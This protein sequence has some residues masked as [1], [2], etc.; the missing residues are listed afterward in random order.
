MSGSDRQLYLTATVLDQAFLDATAQDN[1]VTSLTM[2]VDI[3]SGIGTIH[4]SDRNCYVGS[5]FYQARCKFPL[6]NRQISHWLTNTIEFSS[7][8]IELNNADGT[9]N[10][11]ELGGADYSGF[12]GKSIEVKVGLRDVASTY[13]RIF[14][15]VITPV[16]GVGRTVKSIVLTARD[17]FQLLASDFPAT[18]LTKDVFPNL[19]SDKVGR[20]VPV[21]YGTWND[22]AHLNK[23]IASIPAT[24]V[25]G[26]AALASPATNAQWIIA[27]NALKTFDA[28]N[29]F[30]FRNNQFTA[31]A[32][33]D[34]TNVGGDNR[35]FEIIQNGATVIPP[36]PG[37]TGAGDPWVYQSG[38]TVYVRVVGKDLG[39]YV[40]NPVAQAKDLLKTY[41]GLVDGDFD[42]NWATYRDKND[43]SYPQ[44]AI[45]LIKSRIWVQEPQ[46]IIQYA[47]SLL[48][49]VRLEAYISRTNQLKINSLH[50]EDWNAAPPVDIKNWDVVKDSFK[51]AIDEQNNF[52]RAR[53]LYD[54]DPSVNETLFNTGFYKN[55]AAIT[56][57][58]T[59]PITK[60]ITFP[61]LYIEADVQLQ[62]IEIL[63]L[64]S[65]LSELISVDLTPRSFLL[66]LGDWVTVSV[67]IGSTILDKVPAMLRRIGYDPTSKLPSQLWSMQAVPF[68]GYQD[69]SP[70][71]PR[72][73]GVVGGFDATITAE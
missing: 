6:I 60:D 63:R 44:S 45:A 41:G 13:T 1:L 36:P 53:G 2:V 66:E 31:F 30:I 24:C 18:A 12:V 16:G 59:L 26:V 55:A 23:G 9:F 8:T 54:R 3:D 15:G 57:S 25:N 27:D 71:K 48:A 35:T 7:L 11:L 37:A 17:S 58:G 33:A 10:P 69:G 70:G 61:N 22:P 32:P 28:A 47:T 19:E 20:A 42:A 56:Q 72:L 14:K 39:A 73:P 67:N 50:F 43:I 46:S 38:D 64:A 52:N 49:Q 51:P 34:I 40:D 62:L 29:V 68:P 5:S 65:A 21:I 4:A